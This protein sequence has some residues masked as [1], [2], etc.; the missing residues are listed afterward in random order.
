VS[1]LTKYLK[2]LKQKR[3]D[4]Y[5]PSRDVP[6]A[7]L[8]LERCMSDERKVAEVNARCTT[9]MIRAMG[10]QAENQSRQHRGESP[11]YTEESF[12]KIIE[13]EGTGW[14]AVCGLLY[15]S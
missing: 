10:M 9:A 7:G 2:S 13:E 14:N 12:Q 3:A 15:H 4:P 1:I 11:A 6:A 8:V 5:S